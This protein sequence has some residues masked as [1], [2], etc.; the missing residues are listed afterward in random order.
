LGRA[1]IEAAPPTKVLSHLITLLVISF[2]LPLAL[3]GQPSVTATLNPETAQVGQAVELNVVFQGDP[4]AQAPQIPRIP[5]L[6]MQPSGVR[7]AAN[8]LNGVASRSTTYT[9]YLTANQAGE[10]LIP[11]IEARVGG[12]KIAT[13]PLKL[14][15]LK[16]GPA[17]GGGKSEVAFLKL[18]VPKN[19]VFVGEIFPIELQL[20]LHSQ[21][22]G[23]DLQ[24]PQLQGEGFIFGKIPEP[25]QTQTRLQN[26]IYRLI[27]FK[28]SAVPM[29]SGSLTLGPG[30]DSL[31]LRLPR[32]R[33]QNFFDILSNA[34]QPMTLIS[35]AIPITVH[36]LPRENQPPDFSGAVGNFTLAMRASPTNVTAG[37]P[38]TL[39]FKISGKGVLDSISLPSQTN[40]ARFKLYS[41]TAKVEFK[42]PL[43]MEGV[44]TFEQVVIPESG[45]IQEIPP[46]SF[47]Y[48][49][50]EQKAYRTLRQRPIPLVVG[51][52]TASASGVPVPAIAPSKEPP[53]KQSEEIVHIKSDPGSLRVLSPPLIL[54]GW[55][56]AS[57]AIPFLAWLAAFCWR[58][59]EEHLARNP[60][61]QR[62]RATTATVDKGLKELKAFAPGR[63]S[64][65]FFA[66]VFRLLQEQLGDVL[67]LPASA[68]TD[69]VVEQRLR[70]LGVS[71]S[72]LVS[73]HELFQLCNQARYTQG[74]EVTDPISVLPKVETVLRQL[75]KCS[76]AR[77]RRQKILTTV[78]ILLLL[79]IST[80]VGLSQSHG[81][82][83][84]FEAGNKLYERGNYSAA[85]DAYEQ[86]LKSGKISPAVH[87]NLGN[88]LLKAG[89][90][91]RAIYH[92]R[93]AGTLAPR[94]PDV[95][96][97]LRFARASVGSQP[98]P[99]MNRPWQRLT[100]SLTLDEWTVLAS[101]FLV[102]WLVLLTPTE[103]WPGL[104]RPL[105][106]YIIG[107]G[108]GSA[109]FIL[110]CAAA[111]ITA[112]GNREGIV[113]AKE[114]ILRYGPLDES[115]SFYTLGDGSE[116]EVLAQ[117]GEWVQIRDSSGRIGWTAKLG[118]VA[119]PR[120]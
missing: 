30:R 54:Q 69:A 107:L 102:G 3:Y 65:E 118:L 19:E 93:V 101:C 50:P 10:Y 9:F 64:E 42:D 12:S 91:G 80:S 103:I 115:R 46:F 24:M 1:K 97:N 53:P 2:F 14:K 34:Y 113:V 63:T 21:V 81:A 39:D 52:P 111:A 31:T 51:E 77:S 11:P 87:F 41:P 56:L 4:P 82:S 15:V 104:K 47:T 110:L 96:A 116:V 26:S 92:Y 7:H 83:S 33:G 89:Q 48:F 106:P 90:V 98:T 117:K 120:R 108:L 22:D 38:I 114:T 40:W 45:A 100:N 32:Q 74:K 49:D 72:L 79:H 13:Q 27:I 35:E 5:G 20:Y 25:V 119:L 57:Q 62:R 36:P 86:I 37:D 66:L 99:G 58:R 68:I 61:L 28:M 60:S 67:N 29:K 44:K 75:Q 85:A 8:F 43:G 6:A 16:A 73:V 70:P 17:E 88:S 59:R 71:D 94:D 55:F 95:K 23:R 78:A 18:I 112:F 76:V 105:R 109:L 84:Q